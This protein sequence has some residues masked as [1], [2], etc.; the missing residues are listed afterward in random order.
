MT[1][2]EKNEQFYEKIANSGIY[3]LVGLLVLTLVN[4]Y[5]I[6]NINK[7]LTPTT[8][9]GDVVE[10]K[11]VGNQPQENQPR[12][13][14]QPPI[15]Q[16]SIDDDAVKGSSDA[17]VTIIEFSDYECPFCARHYSQTLPSLINDYV[18]TGKVK[19]VFRDFPLSFHQN[20]QKAA[21]AAECAGEQGK[22]WEMHDKLFDNQAALGVDNL[23]KYA[24]DIGLDTEEFNECLDSGEMASEVQKDF[25]DGQTYGVTG[26]PGFFING[27]K[28]VGAQPYSVFQ[29]VIEQELNS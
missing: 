10:V 21:E 11:P 23:K 19:L 9:N 1:K 24:E 18:E 7:K 17:P 26:T 14:N 5:G 25:N 2:N 22:Y 28:V 6:F 3:L 4:T 15:V 20:A 12:E 27:I 13:Q 8:G 16:V 29:Q